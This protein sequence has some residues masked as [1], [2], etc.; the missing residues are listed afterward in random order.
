MKQ[1]IQHF[2]KMPVAAI[3]LLHCPYSTGI[4]VPKRLNFPGKAIS[5]PTIRV[6][7][8]SFPAVQYGS[9]QSG[10]TGDVNL[11]ILLKGVEKELFLLAVVDVLMPVIKSKLAMGIGYGKF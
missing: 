9:D 8:I 11:K 3:P 6:I 7:F 4:G 2:R 1:G 5:D 10:E